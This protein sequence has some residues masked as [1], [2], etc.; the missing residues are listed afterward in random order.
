MRA[1]S[2]GIIADNLED[3]ITQANCCKETSSCNVKSTE[4]NFQVI[5]LDFL[6]LNEDQDNYDSLSSNKK[7]VITVTNASAH[8]HNKLH[9]S[10]IPL[11][12]KRIVKKKR[13]LLSKLQTT[14]PNA[15]I[16][17]S[18]TSDAIKVVC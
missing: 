1:R 7:Y 15:V 18:I 8:K 17:N 9:K 13:G 16:D 4:L 12:L 6:S 10:I 3:F 11:K 14:V 2:S 5:N